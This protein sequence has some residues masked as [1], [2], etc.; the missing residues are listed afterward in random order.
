MPNTTTSALPGSSTVSAGLIFA[1]FEEL[2][3]QGKT[4]V[5]VTHDP[6]VLHRFDREID[7]RKFLPEPQ[8]ASS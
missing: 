5:M 8:T 6:E 3:E 1:L 7:I 4:I 2:V